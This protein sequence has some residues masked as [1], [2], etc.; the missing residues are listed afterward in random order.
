[1]NTVYTVYTHPDGS[2][3]LWDIHDQQW[4]TMHPLY[5]IRACQ[6]SHEPLCEGL[7][8]FRCGNPSCPAHGQPS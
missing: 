7:A 2:E 6:K 5:P 8:P 3:C 1:V 4:C